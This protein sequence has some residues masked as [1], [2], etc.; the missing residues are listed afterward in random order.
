MLFRHFPNLRKIRS[1]CYQDSHSF[2]LHSFPRRSFC[3]EKTPAY[4]NALKSMPAVSVLCLSPVHF[5]RFESRWVS[6]YAFFKWWRLLCLH[7]HCLRF[8]TSFVTLS[9]NLG[10]LT[11]VSIVLVLWKHLT[12]RHWF[13]YFWTDRFWVGKFTVGKILCVNYPYFTP[14][15]ICNMRL[16]EGIFQQE[17]AIAR[18]DRLFTPNHKLSRCMYTTLVRTSIPLSE[19]FTLLMSRSSGFG[20]S[21]SDSRLF[22]L[23]FASAS[24]N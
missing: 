4:R 15:T 20:S 16:Y 14:S 18:L 1:Y 21:P 22:R 17:P 6:C 13:P 24:L 12:R 23:A 3:A 7:P 9:I 19:N 5:R 11:A 2:P 8:K 10:T